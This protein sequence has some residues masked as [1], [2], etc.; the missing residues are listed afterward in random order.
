M[1]KVARSLKAD[2]KN[3]LTRF[4]RPITNVMSDSVSSKIQ[5]IKYMSRAFPSRDGFR[6]AIYFRCGALDLY[7]H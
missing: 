1:K 4:K 7:P 3:L 6:N 5:W 2:L